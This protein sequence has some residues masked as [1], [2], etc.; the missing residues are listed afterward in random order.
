[1]GIEY[2]LGWLQKVPV[3]LLATVLWYKKLCHA[4]LVSQRVIKS[5]TIQHTL[6]QRA[7]SAQIISLDQ[8]RPPAN[9]AADHVKYILQS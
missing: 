1:M 4:E 6:H 2:A 7:H 5:T 9:L 8:E 3:G